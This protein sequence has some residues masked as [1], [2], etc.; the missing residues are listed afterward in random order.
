MFDRI[1]ALVAI[2]LMDY[3]V[4]RIERGKVAIDGD[5]DRVRLHRGGVVIR[6]WL[7][8]NGASPRIKSDS[9]GATDRG[10]DLHPR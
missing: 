6:K 4:K 9:D 7:L 2:A 3:I 5:L 10:Q 1:I 8:K